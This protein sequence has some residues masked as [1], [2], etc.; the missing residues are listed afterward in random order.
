[1]R[2]TV[3]NELHRLLQIQEMYKIGSIILT[4]GLKNTVFRDVK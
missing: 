3:L 1:M 2:Y 4:A